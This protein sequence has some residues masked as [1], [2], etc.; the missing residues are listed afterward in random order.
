[1]GKRI[2]S[3]RRGRGS[4]RYRSPS[5]RFKGAVSYPKNA[6]QGQ[7]VDIIHDPGR[8]A[9]IMQVKFGSELVH[10]P[11][12]DKINT[13]MTVE[14]G[15]DQVSLGNIMKLKDIPLGQEIYGIE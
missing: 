5:F 12:A 11:A 2:I 9:P 15:T 8:T 7:I 13:N 3:Q 1:M 4:S 6:G 14:A 10:I